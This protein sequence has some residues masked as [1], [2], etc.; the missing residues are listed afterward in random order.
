ESR[1]PHADDKNN[2]QD[3]KQTTLR[4]CIKPSWREVLI[5]KLLAEHKS[6]QVS[7]TLAANRHFSESI[8]VIAIF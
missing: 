7:V 6:S 1:H 5:T 4:K 8:K 3:N 2:E